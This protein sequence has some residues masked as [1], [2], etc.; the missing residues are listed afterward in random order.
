[1]FVATGHELAL[2]E[3]YLAGTVGP[4]S[5]THVSVIQSSRQIRLFLAQ[6]SEWKPEQV[7]VGADL[8]VPGAPLAMRVGSK[9]DSRIVSFLTIA[10][11]GDILSLIW[12]REPNGMTRVDIG[13]LI[14][15]PERFPQRG[16]FSFVKE[17]SRRR[18]FAVS[19]SGKLVEVDLDSKNFS[20]VE[21]RADVVLPGGSVRTLDGQIDELFLVDRR[22]NLISYV[23]DPIRSWKGPQL[24]GNGFVAGSPLVVWRRPDGGKEIYVGGVNA[25]GEMKL[26]R[27]ETT[28]WRMDVAPGWV[29]PAGSPIS[30]FHTPSNVRLFGVNTNGTLFAMHLANTEWR[31]RFIANGFSY[32]T[33]AF[34]PSQ[35][36]TAFSVDAAGDLLT[37]TSGENEI[38]HSNLT[39]SDSGLQ[40]GT[41]I[42]REWDEPKVTS[43]EYQFWN[44]SDSNVILRIR[45]AR[46]PLTVLD[47]KLAAGESHKL[48]LEHIGTRTLTTLI[49]QT[50]AAGTETKDVEIEQK[51]PVPATFP[52]EIEVI[53]LGPGISYQDERMHRFP[54]VQAHDQTEICLGRFSLPEIIEGQSATPI[55]LDAI[56]S[57][58]RG[59]VVTQP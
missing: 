14:D 22:G 56:E 11:S 19:N 10:A 33:T 54:R 26:A 48:P 28:G 9:D 38:F 55:Q 23:R 4:D 53:K 7:E 29:L 41:V 57:A 25:R 24:I 40:R 31:E 27:H 58:K 46:H 15:A 45:D 43:A 17:G 16:D 30:V 47:H 13:A 2:A 1:M 6:G 44:R 34:V 42:K 32:K 3:P 52:Y 36:L 21:D 35:S 37:S 5:L 12:T 50:A 49:K 8:L 20:I 18:V 51:R 39:P 59:Q